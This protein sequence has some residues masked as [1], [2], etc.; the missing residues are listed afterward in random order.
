MSVTFNYSSMNAGKSL[1]L[2]KAKNDYES[3]GRRVICMTPSI[4]TRDGEGVIKS[5]ALQES[6]PA[7]S[8]KPQDNLFDMIN[9]SSELKKISLILLDEAQF[10][11]KEQINQLCL[12]S[13]LLDINVM[14]FGLRTD[15]NGN[16]FEGSAELLAKAD[17]LQEVKNTCYCGKK[18]TMTLRIDKNGVVLK[19]AEQV[20]LGAEGS[21]VSVCRKH[22]NSGSTGK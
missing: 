21:Y 15:S 16:L 4:N 10:F 5:R 7:T 11:T 14:C 3:V 8:I 1:L 22:W 18:A 19:N 13:D 2:L 12:V 20:E 6:I 9:A 17:K